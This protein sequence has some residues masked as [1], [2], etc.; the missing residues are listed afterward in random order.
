MRKL[1]TVGIA[2]MLALT[3]A[4]PTTLATDEG[5]ESKLRSVVEKNFSVAE[6]EDLEKYMD[7]AHPQSPTYQQTRKLAKRMMDR[8]DLE[9]EL[10]LF[11]YI[12]EDGKYQLARVKQKTTN[13]SEA[14]FRDN[15]IVNI[16]AFR[17]HEGEWKN[18]N[19]MLLEREFL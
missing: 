7:T 9:Y 2:L 1:T 17:K 11:N 14:A 16:W 6:E 5:I 13:T 8:Y 4:V 18:W 10:L 19:T 3:L 12:G 15:I